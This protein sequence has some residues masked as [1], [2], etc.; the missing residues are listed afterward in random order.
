LQADHTAFLDPLAVADARTFLS[1]D[2]DACAWRETEHGAQYQQKQQCLDFSHNL[3]MRLHCRF[4][5][6]WRQ[7]V[8]VARK[9]SG[10]ASWIRDVFP[11]HSAFVDRDV[12]PIGFPTETAFDGNAAPFGKRIML[13]RFIASRHTPSR[14]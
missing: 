3:I 1:R 11:A 12:D 2:G 8:G 13:D 6:F 14:E 7:T 5:N 4:C 10:D 9:Q